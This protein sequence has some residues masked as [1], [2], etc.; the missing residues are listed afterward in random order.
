MLAFEDLGDE[1][2]AGRRGKWAQPCKGTYDDTDEL[3]ELVVHETVVG[4]E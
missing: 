3:L 4:V 1:V 2:A